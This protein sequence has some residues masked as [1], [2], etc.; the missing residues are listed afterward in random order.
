MVTVEFIWKVQYQVW[1]VNI[2]PIKIKNREI[3]VCIN[4]NDLNKACPKDD[5]LVPHME[6]LS[7]VRLVT[8]Q[9]L[10]GTVICDKCTYMTLK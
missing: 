1:L 7:D 3:R 5:F 9:Y 10:S 4:F 8:G 2:V 6:L